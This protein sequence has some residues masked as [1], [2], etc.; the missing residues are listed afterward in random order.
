MPGP[1][2]G[3]YRDSVPDMLHCVCLGRRRTSQ[4]W[5][6]VA[7]PIAPLRVAFR[8]RC[9]QSAM[10]RT[11]LFVYHA[12]H[13]SVACALVGGQRS[14]VGSSID[15]QSR[16]A[17]APPPPPPGL[18]SRTLSLCPCPRLSTGMMRHGLL[19]SSRPRPSG[20]M[21]QLWGCWGYPPRA[22]PPYRPS[23]PNSP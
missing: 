14:E 22:Y 21:L 6:A 2:V 20:S 23:L 8:L 11:V 3:I 10:P 12:A 9:C 18:P 7:L 5:L 1:Q 17:H 13:V 19:P 15:S 4:C 16:L